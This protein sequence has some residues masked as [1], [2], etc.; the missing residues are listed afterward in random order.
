MCVYTHTWFKTE[1]EWALH[2]NM[3]GILQN[4]VF[5]VKPSAPED[6]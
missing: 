5:Q 1:F 3:L 4:R 6:Y 2:G